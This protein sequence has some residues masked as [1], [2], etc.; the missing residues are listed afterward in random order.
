MYRKY[1]VYYEKYH[2]YNVCVCV[3]YVYVMLKLQQ[4]EELDIRST[5]LHTCIVY[6]SNMC[7][8]MSVQN[9]A[10]LLEIM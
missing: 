3:P 8:H 2:M 6:T 9:C 7:L 1:S 4:A 5:I 10:L